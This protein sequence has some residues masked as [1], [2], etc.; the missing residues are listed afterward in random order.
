VDGVFGVEVA[1]IPRTG[2]D[3]LDA[4]FTVFGIPDLIQ[5]VLVEQHV[6]N[7]KYP[8]N[9]VTAVGEAMESSSLCT[10]SMVPFC[11]ARNSS[12]VGTN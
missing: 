3:P 2:A 6:A 5:A 1:G 12:P 7:G 11:M 10:A 4:D 9:T 8:P